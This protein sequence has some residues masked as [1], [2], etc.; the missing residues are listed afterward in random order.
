[1]D[2]AFHGAHHTTKHFMGF[3]A[4][5]PDS[6]KAFHLFMT[7][8][9][10]GRSSWMDTFPVKENLGTDGRDDQAAVMFVDIGATRLPSASHKSLWLAESRANQ[11]HA[12]KKYHVP[13]SRQAIVLILYTIFFRLYILA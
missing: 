12:C 11:R 9:T 6:Q 10:K 2:T 8:Y 5:K 4:A 7:G 1:M 13:K 3:L